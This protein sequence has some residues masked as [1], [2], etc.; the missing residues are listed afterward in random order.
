MC[1]T[2][3]NET[4]GFAYRLALLALVESASGCGRAVLFEVVN[5]LMGCKQWHTS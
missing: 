4:K 3:R 1:A 5:R 2:A